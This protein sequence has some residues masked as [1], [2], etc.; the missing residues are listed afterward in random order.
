MCQWCGNKKTLNP[1]KHT[2]ITI[3]E[4]VEAIQWDGQN[5]KEIQEFT[6]G[7]CTMINNKR[8]FTH[9]DYG[10]CLTSIGSYIVKKGKLFS[11]F[12]E[13]RFKEEFTTK[14]RW[15]KEN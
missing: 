12:P 9:T 15:K 2:F 10:P 7:E 6:Q 5:L 1:V 13:Q 11:V 3:P 14:E 8:L 4:E